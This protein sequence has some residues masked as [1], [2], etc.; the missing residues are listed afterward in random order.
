MHQIRAIAKKYSEGPRNFY[1]NAAYWNMTARSWANINYDPITEYQMHQIKKSSGSMP[2]LKPNY[3]SYQQM[4]NATPP[5]YRAGGGGG[6]G[7]G[8]RP[9]GPPRKQ[10]ESVD[11]FINRELQEIE[12]IA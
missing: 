6:G 12:D 9:T 10:Q 1:K 5:F 2:T 4:K 3:S 7:G 8:A 11:S